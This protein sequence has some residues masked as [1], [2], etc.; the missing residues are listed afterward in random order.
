MCRC[1]RITDY[2]NPDIALVVLGYNDTLTRTRPKG[3]MDT[4]LRACMRDA[5]EGE[6]RVSLCCAGLTVSAVFSGNPVGSLTVCFSPR[7]PLKFTS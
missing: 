6:R 1:T 2:A 7:T 5:R 3:K 4:A